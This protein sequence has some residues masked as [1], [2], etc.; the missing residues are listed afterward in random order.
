MAAA[1]HNLSRRALLGAGAAACALPAAARGHVLVHV[2]D[3]EPPLTPRAGESVGG[4]GQVHVPSLRWGRAL[5]AYRR[6][7]ARVAA[8]E[9]EAALLPAARRAFPCDD[10]EERFGRLG[11]RR[12]AALRRL[13]R[14]PAPDL[15]TLSLKL[16]LAVADSAWELDGCESCLDVLSA[17]ARR[18]CQTVAP[19]GLTHC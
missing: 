7:E 17:D 11:S 10:L 6:A 12:L 8:F 3:S 2:P 4:H 19:T 13:L 18:L 1:R 5:A 14:L 15:P 16:D 9:A